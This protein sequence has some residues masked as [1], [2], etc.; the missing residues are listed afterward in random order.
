M[1]H[2]QHDRR[3]QGTDVTTVSCHPGMP[4]HP[5]IEISFLNDEVL[6]LHIL[7]RRHGSYGAR[8]VL[9]GPRIRTYVVPPPTGIGYSSSVYVCH[10]TS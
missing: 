1:M 10:L 2:V 4:Y 5:R 3:L 9:A 6:M 8:E 7:S